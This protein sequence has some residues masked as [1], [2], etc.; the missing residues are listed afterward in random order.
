MN[1]LHGLSC[2]DA[3]VAI[4]MAL[5]W[6]GTIATYAYLVW[7]AYLD[8]PMY[9][10]AD[11]PEAPAADVDDQD[12]MVWWTPEDHAAVAIVIDITARFAG[13]GHRRAA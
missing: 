10:V 4:S 9:P 12:V 1:I 5:V 11:P 3:D 6:G 2:L 8:G 13:A 7:D